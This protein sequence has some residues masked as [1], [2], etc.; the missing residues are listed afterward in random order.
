[1]KS[2]LLVLG[3]LGLWFI[4]FGTIWTAYESHVANEGV[5]KWLTEF[6]QIRDADSDVPVDPA[7]NDM[8]NHEHD[9][10]PQHSL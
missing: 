3:V 5:H 1:M 9:E 2:P 4:A 10:G 6:Q 8:T 7:P